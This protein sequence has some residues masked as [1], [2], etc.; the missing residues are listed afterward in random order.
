MLFLG[1]N[2][3]LSLVS[4]LGRFEAPEVRSRDCAAYFKERPKSYVCGCI[5]SRPPPWLAARKILGYINLGMA[6]NS[7]SKRFQREKI[8]GNILMVFITRF[9]S[10]IC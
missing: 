6:S 3:N 1:Q 8:Q 2:V 9:H 4:L 5:Q 10:F 7:T